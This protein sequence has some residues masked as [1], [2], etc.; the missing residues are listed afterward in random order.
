MANFKIY[1]VTV[2]STNNY[3]TYIKQYLRGKGNL[4][5]KFGQSIKYSIII[6]FYKNLAKNEVGRLVPELSSTSYSTSV[7]CC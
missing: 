5:M 4:A 2:C 7:G 1:D 6:F 3:S